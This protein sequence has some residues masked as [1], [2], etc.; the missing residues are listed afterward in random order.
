MVRVVSR[1]LENVRTEQYH[2]QGLR[3]CRNSAKE[4]T[5]PSG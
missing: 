4:E 1:E 5:F 2:C 3:I